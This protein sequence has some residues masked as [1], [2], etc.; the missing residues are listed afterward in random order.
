MGQ[1]AA[2]CL[3]L[4]KRGKQRKGGGG[5]ERGNGGR[6][7]LRRLRGRARAIRVRWGCWPWIGEGIGSGVGPGLW[8][9]LR[10]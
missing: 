10:R 8:V 3:C 9:A 2:A 1:V 4:G 5:V 6:W 7:G